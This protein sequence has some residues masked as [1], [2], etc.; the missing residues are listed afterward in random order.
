MNKEQKM[1][2]EKFQRMEEGKTFKNVIDLKRA[3]ANNPKVK[4]GPAG[5]L[6][7][8]GTLRKT[9]LIRFAVLAGIDKNTS[10]EEFEKIKDF[11]KIYKIVQ[12]P[13]IKSKVVWQVIEHSTP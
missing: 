6:D 5:A 10:K 3:I 4:M 2:E 12:D 8:N 9:S 13:N 11:N 1:F 7:S